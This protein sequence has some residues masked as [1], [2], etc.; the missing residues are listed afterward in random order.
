[1]R[2]I[3][4]YKIAVC[5]DEWNYVGTLTVEGEVF[6]TQDLEEA[7]YVIEELEEQEDEYQYHILSE[8]LH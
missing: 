8:E 5:D 4:L 2:R 1:M 3:L 6:T 7:Q